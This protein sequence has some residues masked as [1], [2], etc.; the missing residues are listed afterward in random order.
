MFRDLYKQANDEIKGDRTILDKAFIQA[1][2]PVKKTKPIIKYSFA[3]TAVAAV[4]IMGAIF[5]NPQVFTKKTDELGKYPEVVIPTEQEELATE[6]TTS[7]LG[8]VVVPQGTVEPATEYETKKDKYE[9]P[10]K[11]TNAT[12]QEESSAAKD[13]EAEEDVEAALETEADYSIALTSLYE[14]DYEAEIDCE[15]AETAAEE[16]ADF[17]LWGRRASE[18]V[19][20][21]Q[22]E[23]ETENEVFSESE[24]EAK[25]AS[26]SSKEEASIEVKTFSYMQ[27]LSMFVTDDGLSRTEGFKNTD[28]CPIT[29][30]EEAVARAENECT[31]EYDRTNVYYDPYE[32]MWMVNFGLENVVGGDESVYMNSDGITTLIVYGE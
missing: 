21:A 24:T 25:S 22:Y 23:E 2:Q 31:V 20:E 7:T 29:N 14:E 4:I 11:K 6:A 5:A 30:G 13:T 18:D 15:E 26:G 12:A 9:Q 27:D 28:V 1:S 17:A 10:E 32:C 16:S 19:T 8:D 3:T